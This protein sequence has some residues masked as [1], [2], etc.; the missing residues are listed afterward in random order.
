MK[1]K[2]KKLVQTTEMRE[3]EVNLPN[4]LYAEDVENGD[5]KGYVVGN[6]KI[7][8]ILLYSNKELQTIY[9]DE[10]KCED[11]DECVKRLTEYIYENI[12]GKGMDTLPDWVDMGKLIKMSTG[13]ADYYDV[14]FEEENEEDEEDEE[15]DSCYK[16]EELWSD[17]LN[18]RKRLGCSKCSN[19]FFCLTQ[20][21][22]RFPL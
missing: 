20:W 15:E 11:Y 21:G 3:E 6:N 9:H 19:R 5:I 4:G 12:Y 7:I 2:I 18:K 10:D 16:A 8:E 17:V 22:C 1:I 14:D 13:I